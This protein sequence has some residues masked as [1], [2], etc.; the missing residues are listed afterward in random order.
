MVFQFDVLGV[1]GLMVAGAVLWE[2]LEN[3]VFFQVG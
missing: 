3:G 1:I 2:L